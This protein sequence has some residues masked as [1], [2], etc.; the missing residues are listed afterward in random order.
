MDYKKHRNKIRS[1]H[2]IAWS[3]RGALSRLIRIATGETYSHVGIVWRCGGRV[4]LIEAIQG[5]GVQIQPLSEL[6]PFYHLAP[7]IKWTPEIEQFV[8]SQIGKNYNYLDALRG[9]VGLA[10]K[11]TGYQCAELVAEVAIKSGLALPSGNKATPGAVIRELLRL[12]ASLNYV[13]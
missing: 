9:W 8:L 4:M 1:G 2:V 10:P 6:R 11:G 3:G 13:E 12:N 5:K 7:A